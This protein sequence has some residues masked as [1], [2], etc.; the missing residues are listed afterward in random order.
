MKIVTPNQFIKLYQT[1]MESYS[2]ATRHFPNLGSWSYKKIVFTNGCFDLIHVGHIRY[3][4]E[5]KTHG[6]ILVL[7][8]NSDKSI[9][10][11]KGPSRPI[12]PQDER[13]EILSELECV[14]NII[15][16]DSI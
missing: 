9:R 16:F 2:Y 7:A 3:L 10:A 12:I 8:L 13:A 1:P 4:K 15:M 11:I 14:D 6:D 5:A